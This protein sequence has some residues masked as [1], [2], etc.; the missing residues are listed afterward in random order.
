MSHVATVE[1]QITDLDALKAACEKLGLEFVEEKTEFRWYGVSLVRRVP[2]KRASARRLHDKGHG[3]VRS[4]P[5][6]PRQPE[7]L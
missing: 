2:G 3:H 4:L 7:R 6:S 1:V 5:P